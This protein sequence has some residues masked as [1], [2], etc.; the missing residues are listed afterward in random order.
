MSKQ[1][2]DRLYQLISD[3]CAA[4]KMTRVEIA[5]YLGV[6]ERTLYR[7]SMGDANFPTMVFLALGLLMKEE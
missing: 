6:S 7:W 1:D 4:K 5:E 2:A 3:I